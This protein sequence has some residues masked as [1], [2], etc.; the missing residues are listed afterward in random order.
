MN[1]EAITTTAPPQVETTL[2]VSGMTCHSCVG[3]VR[4][5]LLELDEVSSVQ[6]DL[7]SGLARIRHQGGEGMLEELIEAVAE[8][9]Y[10]ASPRA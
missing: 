6:L 1:T 3:H 10:E 9:G 8:A 4:Q 5:A 2:A 7:S